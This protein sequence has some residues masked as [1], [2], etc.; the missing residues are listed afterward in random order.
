MTARLT[1]TSNGNES[2]RHRSGNSFDHAG[3]AADRRHGACA[4]QENGRHPRCERGTAINLLS[5]E[6]EPSGCPGVEP[7][8]VDGARTRARRTTPQA[9]PGAS[10][11]PW[12]NTSRGRP[13]AMRHKMRPSRVSSVAAPTAA[14]LR[15]RARDPAPV[16]AHVRIEQTPRGVP[17]NELRRPR[18]LVARQ[19]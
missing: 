14:Q 16:L 19:D 17:A 8:A 1:S 9:T 4:A 7:G 5:C 3:T 6:H 12:W 15:G 18:Q 10:G 13:S 11:V 2:D